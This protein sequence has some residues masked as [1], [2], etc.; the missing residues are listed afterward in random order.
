MNA[1]RHLGLLLCVLASGAAWADHQKVAQGLVINLGIV[2]AAKLAQFPVEAATHGGRLPGGAQHLLVSLS[3]GKSGAHVQA[4]KVT[5]ELR[6]PKGAVQKKDLVLGRTGEI[7]DY[8]EIFIFGWSGKYRV[9]VTVEPKDGK[10]FRAD[11][12]WSHQV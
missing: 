2:P 8:S 1:I 6:D 12:T 10:P 9:R 7:P 5:V 4:A 11:F 3:D